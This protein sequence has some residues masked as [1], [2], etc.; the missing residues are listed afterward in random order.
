MR[1]R[2]R[3]LCAITFIAGVV[4]V[5]CLQFGIVNMMF[6]EEATVCFRDEVHQLNDN[7]LTSIKN[8]FNG[9][10]MY[11]ENLYCGFSE[12]VSIK[13]D[14]GKTFCIA[15]DSCPVVYWKEKDKYITL[16]EDELTQLYKLLEPYG[17]SF[18]CL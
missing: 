13:F 1:K 3:L 7:E 6:V 12:E 9:K 17:F 15:Q 2:K 11:R 8:I 10:I 4:V 16:S 14:Q 5:I 18:P